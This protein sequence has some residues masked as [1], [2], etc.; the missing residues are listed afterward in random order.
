MSIKLGPLVG[1][2]THNEAKIW[3]Q[4]DKPMALECRV[5]TDPEGT[6]QVPN[7]PFVF[8]IE[9]AN[10]STG[11]VTVALPQDDKRHYYRIFERNGG[12]SEQI[13]QIYSFRSFPAPN[14]KIESL[15]FGLVSCHKPENFTDKNQPHLRAMWR[16]LYTEM[17]RKNAAFLLAVGDQ[18][19]ADHA[20]NDVWQKSLDGNSQES[21]FELYRDV[22]YKH[23]WFPEVQWVLKHFPTFMIW[24]DHE[25]TNGWGSSKKHGK[26]RAQEI[27]QVARKVY[28]EFQHSH[29]PPTLPHP[30]N[31]TV[32]PGHVPYYYA[33]RYGPAAF[34]V[35]DLRGNRRREKKSKNDTK[36]GQLLGP[37]QKEALKHWF[38]SKEAKDSKILFVISSVPMFHLRW[39]LAML[40]SWAK[41]DVADQWSSPH[42]KNERGELVGMLF[43]K[44]I[45]NGKR[46]VVILGGDVH[47]GTVAW[48]KEKNQYIHQCTSSPISNRPAAFWDKILT[49]F[50]N[51][52]TFHLEH[53][54]GNKRRPVTGKIF[55]RFRQRNFGI[56][57]V[58]FSSPPKTTLKMYEE[59]NG[60]S[61]EILL[62]GKCE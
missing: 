40:F 36:E 55:R 48:I 34:L 32:T 4:T 38:A 53:P 61:E 33:F 43:D 19:Y 51:E 13:P 47:V 46:K 22:Y 5:Y 25:I 8:K 26:K 3:V 52:F 49:R 27:F 44:Y 50:G 24:D 56:V 1:S 31:H 35:L 18:V 21:S 62:D 9:E 16:Y 60:E 15:S 45:E 59:L 41:T 7:S 12:S 42:N 20:D 57:T 30:N 28:E 54:E 37:D 58:E 10:G 39:R 23:W 17:S 29:N 6:S 11:V 14:K 2:T